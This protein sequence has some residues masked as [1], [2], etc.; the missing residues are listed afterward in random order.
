MSRLTEELS[1]NRWRIQ[2]RRSQRFK[3]Q[4]TESQ[5][6]KGLAGEH[7]QPN[8]LRTLLSY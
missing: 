7:F 3:R 6:P 2:M 5:A 4:F 1:Q 8:C